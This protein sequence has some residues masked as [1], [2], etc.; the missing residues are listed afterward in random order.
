MLEA[1]LEVLE[2][3]YFEVK[4]AFGGL[5]DENVWKRP[6]ENLLSVG[7]LAGHIAYWEAVRFAGEGGEHPRPDLMKCKVSSPLI[8]HRFH[9]PPFTLTLSPSEQQS[10]MTAE[11]V[12]AELLRVHQESVAHFKKED[13]DLEGHREG[14]PPE[15]TYGV[16]LRYNTFH[17]AYHAGQ[18]YSA[19]HLLGEVTPDN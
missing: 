1:Y 11:Q 4:E 17:V 16:F 6:A 3:C 5:R 7:E 8:D 18:I 14:W 10:A 2:L 9:Y 15:Q 12:L 19:R 13:P